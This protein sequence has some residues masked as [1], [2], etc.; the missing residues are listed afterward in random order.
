MQIPDT[1]EVPKKVYSFM[2]LYFRI[3]NAAIGSYYEWLLI[4]IIANSWF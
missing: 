4:I 3:F 2:S 1:Q